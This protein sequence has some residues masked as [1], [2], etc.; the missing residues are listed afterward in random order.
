MSR[1]GQGHNRMTV[2]HERVWFLRS[3]LTEL[4]N[5]RSRVEQAEE[6]KVGKRSKVTGVSAMR[7]RL[8]RQRRFVF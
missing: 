5:L 3:Q 7:R 6:R 4:Q 2:L 8:R 1:R